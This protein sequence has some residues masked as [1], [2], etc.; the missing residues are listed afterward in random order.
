MGNF[1]VR[2]YNYFC[3]KRLLFWAILVISLAIMVIGAL[4]V[5]Y[6][7]DINNFFPKQEKS[8]SL[9]FKNLK[10]KDK[11]AL[12][13]RLKGADATVDD[14]IDAA[15]EFAKQ[16]NIVPNFTNNASIT[17]SINDSIIDLMTNFVYDNLPLFIDDETFNS[18]DSLT[19]KE[20]I[21]AKMESNYNNLLSPMGGY[22]AKFIFNDPLSLGGNALKEFESLSSGSN[23]NYSM[24][25]N[26]I[27]SKDESTL[28]C[29]ITPSDNPSRDDNKL[30]DVIEQTITNIEANYSNIDVEYFG[31]PAMAVYNARQIKWDSIVTLNIALLIIVI[32]ITIAFRNKFTILLVLTPAIYGALFAL[33]I[34]SITTESI[35]LIAVGSGSIIFGIALS[36]SIHILAHI[37][38]SPDVRK[39]IKELAYPLTVGSF[40]TIGAFVGLL[41]TD[42]QLLKDL[43]LFASLTL[44]GTTLFALIFLPH[45]ILPR[46]KSLATGSTV[47]N[48]AAEESTYNTAQTSKLL[49]F[50]D[51]VSNLHLDKSKLF[52][53]AVVI[54]TIVCGVYST[55]VKFNSNM[56]DL[57]FTP[58]H[59]AKSQELLNSF[60]KLNTEESTTLFIASSGCADSAAIRYQ[61][62]CN[63]LDSLCATGDIISYSSISKYIL[64]SQLQKERLGR[65]SNYWSKEKRVE[66]AKNIEQAAAK[67]EFEQGAFNNFYT[68]VNSNYNYLTYQNGG[69]VESLLPDWLSLSTDFSS[70]IAHVRLNENKK[71]DVY[72]NFD[73]TN[74]VI[75]ADRAYFAGKMAEEVN[76]NF[77]LILTISSL[78]IF[79]AMILSYGRLELALICFMPMAVSWLIILGLMALFN[80]EFNI[81]TIILSTFIFGIGDDFSIFM[82][83]GLLGK[84]KNRSGVLS[85][86]RVAIFF[87]AFTVIVGMGALI[88]AEHPAMSSLGL[89]SLLGI[90]VVVIVTY[91]VQPFFFRLF[92]SSH[93][94][95]G[96]FPFTLFRLL[97]TIYSFGLFLFGCFIVQLLILLLHLIP[98]RSKMRKAIVGSFV[99]GAAS[100]FIHVIPNIKWKKINVTKESFSK[101]S[102]VIANHQSFIDILML[103]GIHNKF[104][105]LTNG[106]VWNS[107][108]FGKI[109]RYLDFYNVNDG[110][111]ELAHTLKSKVKDGYSILI[112]PEGTRSKD[113]KIKR[114]HKGAFYLA[115]KMKLDI[116]PIIIYGNGLISSKTQPFYIKKGIIATKVLPRIAADS[117]EFGVDYR[118]RTAKILKYCR[119]EYALLLNEY[120]RANNPYFRDA[121]IKN[122]IFKGPV[123]EWY[124]RVKFIME[125]WYDIYD[126]IVPRKG[127]IVDLGCGY[128]AVSYMLSLL[129]SERKITAVDYDK[130]KIEV[131]KCSYSK[132]SNIEFYHSD[133]RTFNSPNADAFIISDVLHY[134]DI[135][136]QEEVISRCVERLNNNGVIIIRDG[137]SQS[138]QKHELTT[139]SEKWSTQII[140]FN[141]TD[142]PLCFIS[143]DIVSKF[144]LDN[145]LK[146]EIVESGTK[147]SN[148]LFLLSKI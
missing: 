143:R 19:S 77:Y 97:V 99:K 138:T 125:S 135:A 5:K 50:V 14:A 122:Y 74:G 34:I 48:S 139:K 2:I 113:C 16:I 66:V 63:T 38:H 114:F 86:H 20:A 116:T 24:V 1:F 25:D 79:I 87:S 44:V 81:V 126:R 141:K 13:F 40:T 27:F 62:M 56:M 60:S 75:A 42:S 46:G 133:I 53:L 85:H 32:F 4:R 140:K 147:T 103:L 91:T 76:Y 65:W 36:Y 144:A 119:E 124:M 96:S 90:L 100:V 69:Q 28:L 111:G 52:V 84:Y 108:F 95:K 112:F 120:N 7:E 47:N 55:K 6:E 118:E 101:P 39:M 117:K 89:I 23:F 127:T 35:S 82:M 104:V 106:W 128:G 29:Y 30:V 145:S 51:R 130:E 110:Y 71:V 136:A 129:S 54:I 37:N 31:A 123:L 21:A 10:V 83:D 67:F 68:L 107:P 26:Y 3:D 41:F 12:M 92:I 109:V 57:N 22:I 72:N 18:L 58:P 88:F 8:A 131:A 93:T 59:L 49:L 102:V 43:G 137:D 134:L 78:L 121:L 9:I 146:M 45:F 70:Y 105:M 132:N 148:T 142:G 64:P 15:E 11:I 17:L 94:E 73:T 80:I 61:Q 98:M 115:E 33:S